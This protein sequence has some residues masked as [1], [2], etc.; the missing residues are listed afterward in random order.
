[1]ARQENFEGM[2]AMYEQAMKAFD[3]LESDDNSVQGKKGRKLALKFERAA[4][5]Q[6]GA[7]QIM[8]NANDLL[9]S[10]TKKDMSGY[11]EALEV[12]QKEMIELIQKSAREF[13]FVIADAL[14]Q[15]DKEM[16]SKAI[17]EL[18]K[19]YLMIPGTAGKDKAVY[20]AKEVL[21][22]H[23][24]GDKCIDTI[25][26]KQILSVNHPRQ[27]DMHKVFLGIKPTEEFCKIKMVNVF[28]TDPNGED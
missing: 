27:I 5:Y 22:A 7:L 12:M 28:P 24:C 4:M 23:S 11:K 26:C 9:K 14:S 6:L 13:I 2:D 16:W 25:L 18:A 1:M 21:K 8:Q 3:E 20:Y 10:G 19:T 15:N 17:S